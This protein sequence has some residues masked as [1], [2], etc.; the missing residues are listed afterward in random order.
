ATAECAA[1][2][3]SCADACL[4][5]PNVAELVKCIRLNVDCADICEMTGRFFARASARDRDTLR[6][7][8]RACAAACRVCG[9]EC[10]RHA[11][12]MEHCR[13]CADSC[14]ACAEACEREEKALV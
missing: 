2:C 10:A 13:I 6:H 7:L 5:E 12:H 4:A 11:Q 14:R 3:A 8:L 9:E 1:I